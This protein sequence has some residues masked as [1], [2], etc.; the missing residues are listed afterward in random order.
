MESTVLVDARTHNLRS[1]DLELRP[2]ELVVVAGVSGAGKSSLA[3]DTLYAEGQR[4][5]VESFSAYARQFLERRDRPPVAKLDPVPAAIAVDRGAPVRTSRSTVG[6]MTELQDYLRLLWA[7]ASTIVCD[8]CGRDVSR[9]TVTGATRAI[10]DRVGENRVRSVVTYPVTA[11]DPE[12]WLGVR[13]SLVEQGYRRVLVDSKTVD[14]D[15]LAPSV[16]VARGEVEVVVDRLV[17]ERDARARVAEAIGTAM[18]KGKRARVHLEDGG[19][20]ARFAHGLEC[21][22]CQK[23]FA[24][25]APALF[26]FQSPLGACS[27]CKGFGRTIELDWDKVVPDD[28]LSIDDGAIK[29]WNGPKSAW[30]RKQVRA[31]CAANDIDPSAPWK[32]LTTKEKR[33]ILEGDGDYI[34]VKGWFDW[35]ETKTYKMHVRVFLSR[36]RKYETCR[37]CNGSRLKPEVERYRVAGLSLVEAGRTPVS[38][39]RERFASIEPA[40]EAGERV[41]SEILF[42]LG[43]LE[44][45]GLGYLTLERP[46]RT[47]SGGEVQR[48]ALTAA[49]GTS[50]TGTLMVL[51]EPTVG[52]HPRDAEKLVHVARGLARLGNVVVVVEHDLTVISS[53]DRVIELGPGAGELGGKIV[54]DGAPTALATKDTPTGRALRPSKSAGRTRRTPGAWLTLKGATGHNLK[55]QDARF[56]LGVFTCV[57]G[58]SGSGKSSLVSETL[59]AAASRMLGAPWDG[60][61]LPFTGLEGISQLKWVT[62]VDQSP[63]GRTSRGNAATYTG[64]WDAVRAGFAA[65]P[66]AKE[67]GY[68]P[69][70]FSFNVEG[71]RCASCQGEGFETVEMQFLADVSFTCP[72]CKGKRFRDEVLELRWHG[73]TV[74]DVLAMS[75]QRA[76]DAFPSVKSLVK[77]LAPLVDVG[78]GYLP[79]GQPLSMLSGGEAQRLKL[80]RALS[81][82]GPG[83][84]VVLDE[85]TAGLHRADVDRV[86]DAIDAL[87]ARDA[88]VIAVE[89]DPHV[90]ARADWVI[91][92][93]P[94]AADAGGTI[95]AEGPPEL[96][97]RSER[98]RFAPFLRDALAGSTVSSVPVDRAATRAE[99]PATRTSV[100]VVGAREH[101]LRVGRLEI[102]REKLVAFTGPSGSGKSSMAFDVVYAEG[103][104]RFL[105]T[106][107]PYARQYLP[108]LGR[109]D[110]DQISGIPPAISLE[111]RTA[112]AGAMSTVATVTEVAHYLRLLF[113][114]VGVPHCP[115]CDLAI[116]ARAPEVIADDLLRAHGASQS[117]RVLA[118]VVRARKGLHKEAMERAV[119]A[120]IERVRVDGKEHSPATVPPLAKSKV[121]DVH[122]D[123]GAVKL[124][125][126]S[127]LVALL[128]RATAL[129]QGHAIVEPTQSSK[130]P[131]EPAAVLSTRRACP[132]CG[133][134][135]PELDPRHF[136]FNTAQGRCA[137]CEGAGVDDNGRRC[138]SCEGTRLAPIPR[139]VRL[140]A[141]RYHEVV[142]MS[143]SEL[144]AAVKDVPMDERQKSIAR[145]PMTELEARLRTL[146]E[147]GLDYLALD[148]RANTLSGGEMQRLRL[149]AQIGA[150]L[151][152]VLYVLDEPTIGLHASDTHRLVRAMRR[153]VDRGASVLVV[154]HDA[155][156]IRAADWIVDMGP[157]GGRGGGQ[158]VAEGPTARVLASADSPTAKALEVAPGASARRRA[159]DDKSVSWLELRGVEAHNLQSVRVQFPLGRLVAVAGVSG[160]GKSTLVDK[161]LFPAACKELGLEC[162]DALSYEKLLGASALRGAKRIDQSPIGRTPRSVPATYVG[163]WDEI[164]KMLAATQ[165]ARAK[166]WG[167]TRF[168]FNT[169]TTQGG[170]R[171]EACD[172][173]GV[174][175]VEMSFL[176]DVVVPCEVCEG[177]RFSRET[178]E[179][180][181]HGYDAGE[182][183]ALTVDEAKAV[184]A[185]VASLSRALEL[186]SS[187]GLGYM[188]LG[189]GSHTL[190]GG[191]AQRVKLATELQGRG[192]GTLYV[193]DEP[194]TG[195]HVGDVERLV[196]VLQRL[197]DRGDSVIVVEHHPNVLAAADWLI[198]LGPGGGK[199]GGRLV[200]AAT[201]AQIATRDTATGRVLREEMSAHKINAK[202]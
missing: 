127:K 4:R 160:S 26:N 107:S 114:K 67:R 166:G 201:P 141:W 137:K 124:G 87:I 3:L 121:H 86:L 168:S 151:T 21:A 25:P 48:V 74:A 24:D 18:I 156:V 186:L 11:V 53:A 6:T 7:R 146:D 167:P 77:A 39:L 126:Q 31:Y 129:A 159:M 63:L 22:Q 91:D 47:L 10:L 75:A 147:L 145:A 202:R 23:S 69:G 194:T 190:S 46:S 155:A 130:Q 171:C 163:L 149:A 161:V 9:G 88:T 122:Y 162:E 184:F 34:G 158:V 101:N 148:R 32:S 45:V 198:E 84:L 59:V 29:P 58:V 42:R 125:E 150:G 49:L 180:K 185:Q 95:V 152:G 116:G 52:L 28:R 134:G 15:E 54:F 62:F 70:T 90:A 56:P 172:G 135:V 115:T 133:R 94:E 79:L 176:P 195:L 143:P 30:E 108:S 139:A 187:L 119:T 82:A 1:V 14:I 40:D 50:L 41:V 55:G 136:S 128:Q 110:V 165:A 44:Q 5:F 196:S 12:R 57:T 174:K 118:P 106:L 142:G 103:Q 13:E 38:A 123:L 33:R 105:E 17:I 64:A 65:L 112:R 89:H 51:D 37:A 76:M 177:M 100:V 181:L 43:Y 179:I 117:V 111:Q 164:R 178:R 183:L 16:A 93:G 27:A 35:L 189:Q 182:L 97:A 191:E 96:V 170:G 73:H 66:E 8:T 2:G 175:H 92:L 81:E 199:H 120:G 109:A 113:A 104:R 144:R 98:S 68:T 197:V 19:A 169:A 78:L 102:P 200:A 192:G 140:G 99:D 36:F 20:V 72:D 60:A 71:G 132:K 157:S 131:K 138:K 173:A 193:L 61:P 85:P 83:T 80:A 153:L 188:A 154:E